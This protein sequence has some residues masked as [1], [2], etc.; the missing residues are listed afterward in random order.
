MKEE[1]DHQEMTQKDECD[2]IEEHIR[3]GKDRSEKIDFA[4]NEFKQEN[5]KLKEKNERTLAN[6]KMGLDELVKGVLKV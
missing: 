1:R 2:R 3:L 5:I 6:L 4:I